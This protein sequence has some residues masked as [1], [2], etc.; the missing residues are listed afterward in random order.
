[1]EKKGGSKIYGR[2]VKKKRQTKKVTGTTRRPEE[3]S[4]I[5]NRTGAVMRKEEIL[6]NGR[7]I[8]Q[9]GV[10]KGSEEESELREKKQGTK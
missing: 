6:Q 7:K 3:L 8:L 1:M 10:E 5:S 4:R 2:Q 9:I